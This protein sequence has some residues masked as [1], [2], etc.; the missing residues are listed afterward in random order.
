MMPGKSH[1]FRLF[2]FV[3]FVVSTLISASSFAAVNLCADYFASTDEGL[4]PNQ[5]GVLSFNNG[6]GRNFIS[7][8]S[9][10]GM[11][12]EKGVIYLT[13]TTDSGSERV[14]ASDKLF[15][16]IKPVRARAIV[17]DPNNGIAAPETR[18]VTFVG[19]RKV[20]D[21]IEYIARRTDGR[22]VLVWLYEFLD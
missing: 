22:L 12:Q 19:A 6:A 16:A 1:T 20:E 7:V 13:L 2:T 10:R 9:L 8:G 15:H 5:Y 21:Q 18:I 17:Q 4:R 14:F 3:P 11:T